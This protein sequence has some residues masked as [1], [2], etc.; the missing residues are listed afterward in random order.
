MVLGW[1]ILY[2]LGYDL[3]LMLLFLFDVLKSKL[4]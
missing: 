4:D 3:K 1:Y 2:R